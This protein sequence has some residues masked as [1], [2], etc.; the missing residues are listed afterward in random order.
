MFGIGKKVSLEEKLQ[1]DSEIKALVEKKDFDTAYKKTKEYEKAD[2]SAAA[3]FLAQMYLTGQGAKQ[4]LDKAVAYINTYKGK[5]PED[6]E[7]WFLGSSIML[8]VGK[9]DDATEWLLRSEE[10]GKENLDRH[11]AEYSSFMGMS[12]YNTAC[13]TLHI[14]E[15]KALNAKAEQYFV[16]AMERYEKLY[17]ELGEVLSESD[18]TQMGYNWHYLHYLA[19]NVHDE[20]GAKKWEA[21]GETT[22][23][24]M[25]QAGFL[26]SATYIRA[27]FAEN[28]ANLNNSQED[29]AL[30]KEYL[31]KA[32]ALA[33]E[34]DA[35]YRD[36]FELVW[37]EYDRLVKLQEK[38]EKKGFF[39]RGRK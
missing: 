38:G 31:E 3:Y 27:M 2:K 26:V 34:Q 19:L 8:N 7:G 10:L 15:R 21:K 11:I 1:W 39:K 14:N 22:L 5:F 37:K 35:K 25:E 18:W 28:K 24:D 6:P 23:A 36:E 12:Y 16:M 9:R 30:A 17:K 33:G 13:L 4:D 20:D 29:L 32:S